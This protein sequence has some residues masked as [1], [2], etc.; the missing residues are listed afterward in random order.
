MCSGEDLGFDSWLSGSEGW[1][2][3]F[4]KMDEESSKKDLDFFVALDVRL[5]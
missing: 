3:P 2:I 1:L 5:R 4:A